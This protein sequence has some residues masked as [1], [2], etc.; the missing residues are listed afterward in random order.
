MTAQLLIYEQ[1]VPVSVERHGDLSVKS[2]TDFGFARHVNSVPLTAAEISPAAAEFPVVFTGNEEAVVPA[3]ILGARDRQN[4]F[5]DEA[6][7][8]QASYVPAFLRRYPFVFASGDEGANFTLCIDEEFAGCN[9]DGIGERLFDAAGART[10]YLD[11]VLNFLQEFQTQFQRT[12]AF[13]EQIRQLG[14]LEPMMAQFRLADG[15][16]LALSGFYA[17]NRDKLKALPGDTLAE[18][19]R[20]D[21]LELLYVH[22]HS[23]RN[24]RPMI[25]RAGAQIP[26]ATNTASDDELIGDSI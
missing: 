4:L 15:E 16:E 11:S 18:L 22:L 2:G 12:R 7:A 24:F 13:A 26:A 20:G 23:L 9:R 1:A 25:E 21:A 6:G 3:A 17:V 10:S 14:V 5:L 8:W 19:A